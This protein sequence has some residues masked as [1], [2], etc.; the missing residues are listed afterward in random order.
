MTDRIVEIRSTRNRMT[1][2]LVGTTYPP[3]VGGMETYLSRLAREFVEAGNEVVVATRF[4]ERRPLDSRALYASSE[5]MRFYDENGVRI[6]IISPPNWLR[7]AFPLLYRMHFYGVTSRL[8]REVAV[9]ALCPIL[10]GVLKGC[11][12]IHYRGTGQEMLGSAAAR[13]A[14]EMGVPFVVTPHTHAGAWGDGVGDFQLY[15]KAD[16]TIA[17]TEDERSRLVGGGLKEGS[18][19]VVKHGS[20]STS[21]A[22]AQRFR[23]KHCVD[24]P[25]V[26][27][28][29]ERRRQKDIN[30]CLMQRRK[31]GNDTR[32]R[33]LSW[34]VPLMLTTISEWTCCRI[35]ASWILMC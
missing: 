26:F 35:L 33:R 24:G 2:G 9:R 31:Y 22:S 5:R 27:Y 29:A 4:V 23:T 34:Q 19:F 12:V 13:V 30:C 14:A 7:F 20:S 28:W 25:M 16:K 15:G 3:I 18:V 32:R 6:T 8:A 11:D 10:R 21:A 17:L 1:I